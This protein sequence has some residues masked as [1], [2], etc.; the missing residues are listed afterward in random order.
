MRTNTPLLG[1][2]A[3]WLAGG[4]LATAAAF[5]GG[6]DHR[7]R[8][9]HYDYRYEDV[10]PRPPRAVVVVRRPALRHRPRAVRINPRAHGRPDR[11]HSGGERPSRGHGRP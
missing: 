6:C 8:A 3:S 9:I 4:V 10:M 7:E 5:L 1:R 11:H 2:A